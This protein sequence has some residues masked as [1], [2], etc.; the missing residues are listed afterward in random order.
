MAGRV[1]HVSLDLL[2]RQLRRPRR[3]RVRQGRR[4]RADPRRGRRHCGSRRSSPARACS[5]T[6]S[7]DDVWATWIQ[8][9]YRR[10]G[11]PG[12]DERAR[13]PHAHPD[14]PRRPTSPPTSTS[15]SAATTSPPTPA[16]DGSATTSSATSPATTTTRAT[17]VLRIS[18]LLAS[19]VVTADGRHVGHVHEVRVVQDGPAHLGISAATARRRPA[20][21]SRHR[22]RAPRLLPRPGRRTV[23]AAH[24]APTRRAPRP[25]D[26]DHR[27]RRVGRRTTHRHAR[28][29]VTRRGPLRAGSRQGCVDMECVA[30]EGVAMEFVATG[31]S[32][33]ITSNW[34]I[35]PASSWMRLWQWKT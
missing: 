24:P 35:I 26:P 4:P 11:T 27:R 32:S 14:R 22:R 6:A 30:M 28:Q 7:G 10:A 13:R 19:D 5:G 29:L 21:R 15:P 31:E 34:A 23:A 8:R 33:P 12:E 16:N 20:R 1:L 18:D 25:D 17:D 3:R 9:A 2:D